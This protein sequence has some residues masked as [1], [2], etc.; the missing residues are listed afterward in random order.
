MGSFESEPPSY[1]HAIQSTVDP[2]LIHEYGKYNDA[3]VDSYERGEQFIQAFGA[4]ID[5]YP[6]HLA[7]E[8]QV[9][10]PFCLM[11]DLACHDNALFR[12]P[13]STSLYPAFKSDGATYI[14]FWPNGRPQQ[15]Q[16]DTD[17]TIQGSH[18]WVTIAQTTTVHYFEITVEMAARDTVLSIGLTTKPY[19]LFRMPGWN[20]H[21]VGY[22]SDDGHAFCDDSTGGKQFWNPWQQGDT[23]GCI[24]HVETG[25]VYFSLNGYRINT[26]A[27][28]GL[29]PHAYYPS[30]ASDGPAMVRVN[31]GA[32]PFKYP[33]QDWIGYHHRSS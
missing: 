20:K 2:S 26:P 3:S 12:H 1:D 13:L 15:Q 23:V 33:C 25:T 5:Q 7:S 9:Q 10:G 24:Y 8:I 22:H 6:K 19:P 27:F 4:Q 29:E 21:S 31:F 30:I 11:L 16:G 17:V 14:H 32:A 28:S 18:P